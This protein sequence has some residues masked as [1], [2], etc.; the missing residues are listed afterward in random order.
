M[1]HSL[2]SLP[3]SIAHYA[4]QNQQ[5]LHPLQ[6]P[7]QNIFIPDKRVMRRLKSIIAFYGKLPKSEPFNYGSSS[8]YRKYPEPPPSTG[9][10][11]EFNQIDDLPLFGKFK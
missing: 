6:N 11:I 2:K 7:L 10:P 8:S 4:A 3:P 5:P 1:Q 9:K